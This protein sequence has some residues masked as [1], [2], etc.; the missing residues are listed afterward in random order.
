MSS[1]PT[2]SRCDLHGPSET[3]FVCQHI[4]RGL[5]HRERVGFYWTDEDPDDPH[6]DA[7]CEACEERRIKAGGAWVGSAEKHLR[8]KTL[9][10]GCDQVAKT[11]HMGGDPWS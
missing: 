6:P 1:T 8:V 4:A 5:F 9:C 2:R 7:L 10:A 11:F 3:A